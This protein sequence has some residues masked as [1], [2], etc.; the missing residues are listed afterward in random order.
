MKKYWLLTI[1]LFS[2]VSC[3]QK[4]TNEKQNRI[5]F[6]DLKGF[7]TEQVA[8]DLSSIRSLEKSIYVNG[9]KETKTLGKEF[10][11]GDINGF[12]EADINKPAWSDKYK[13]DSLLDGQNHLSE[14]VYTAIDTSMRTRELRIIYSNDKVIEIKIE[15]ANKSAAVDMIQKMYYTVNKGYSIIHYQKLA[16]GKTDSIVTSVV[17]NKI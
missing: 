6:F 15:K 5:N 4:E 10:I 17:Y 16:I 8:M 3:S 13:V 2:I 11:T 1:A 14:T 12:K 7:L 9:T